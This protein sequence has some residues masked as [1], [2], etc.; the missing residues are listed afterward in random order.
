MKEGVMTDTDTIVP[1]ARF[2][3]IRDRRQRVQADLNH[4]VVAPP[5]TDEP[6]EPQPPIIE[7]Q[8]AT[9]QRCGTV[10]AVAEE[11]LTISEGLGRCRK[12]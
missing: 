2:L 12:F 6:L 7:C 5:P 11:A 1:Y 9:N 8:V 10:A 3:E 4:I